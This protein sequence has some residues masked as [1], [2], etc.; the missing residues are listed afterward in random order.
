[1]CVPGCICIGGPGQCDDS[2]PGFDQPAG[3]QGALSIDVT[4]IGVSD[5]LGFLR[6]A[7]CSLGCTG[8]QQIKSSLLKAAHCLGRWGFLR[9]W[10]LPIEALKETPPD[11]ETLGRD[12][13]LE[14]QFGNT[15]V[16]AVGIPE[17]KQGVVSMAEK[18]RYGLQEGSGQRNSIRFAPSLCEYI[19]IRHAAERLRIE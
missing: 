6:N 4:A 9:E 13:T 1:M 19:G 10:H 11:G 2:S 18:A 8:G 14:C 7:K 3:Q 5:F 15:K 16:T 17:N 12:A